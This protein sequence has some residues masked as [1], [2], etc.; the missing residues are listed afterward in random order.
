MESIQSF[1]ELSTKAHPVMAAFVSKIFADMHNILGTM[2]IH[3]MRLFG[4]T[5]KLTL[6]DAQF[7][8]FFMNLLGRTRTTPVV[9]EKLILCLTDGPLRMWEVSCVTG[10]WCTGGSAR[11]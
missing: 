9:P 4:E 10:D 3:E 7:C 5:I 2:K 11:K 8:A 6:K 1:P